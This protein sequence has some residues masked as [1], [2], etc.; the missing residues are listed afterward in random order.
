M[1]EEFLTKPQTEF[2][3]LLQASPPPPPEPN[4][5]K[6][7]YRYARVRAYAF[8]PGTKYLA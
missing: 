6:Q 2:M 7:A 4:P 8:H 3:K 1:L 5:M